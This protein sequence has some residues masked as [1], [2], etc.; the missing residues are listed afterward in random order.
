MYDVTVFVYEQCRAARSTR[1]TKCQVYYHNDTYFSS[2]QEAFLNFL[3]SKSFSIGQ[4]TVLLSNQQQVLLPEIQQNTRFLF[5]KMGL[6]QSTRHTDSHLT[7]PEHFLT[8]GGSLS[9]DGAGSPC[10]CP[11][12]DGALQRTCAEHAL[13]RNNVMASG[14]TWRRMLAKQRTQLFDL[15][16]QARRHC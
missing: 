3:L 13:C 16:A 9:K 1:Q 14:V 2:Y 7:D 11:H 12:I 5:E 8:L 10:I 15:H 4:V 6:Y